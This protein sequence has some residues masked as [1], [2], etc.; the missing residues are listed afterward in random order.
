MTSVRPHTN[1]RW[2]RLGRLHF[3]IIAPRVRLWHLE[4]MGQPGQHTG[5]RVIKHFSLSLKHWKFGFSACQWQDFSA[6]PNLMRRLRNLPLEQGRTWIGSFLTCK[7]GWLLSWYCWL[8]L[9]ART[10]LAIAS[11]TEKQI[12]M[13]GR[14]DSATPS[15]STH[16]SSLQSIFPHL[17]LPTINCLSAYPSPGLSRTGDVTE[18]CKSARCQCYKTLLVHC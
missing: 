8:G 16:I 10:C 17:S 3:L 1:Q 15:S 4:P 14:Q 12:F 2:G 18:A 6:G 5:A 9:N 11:M 13:N 7:K